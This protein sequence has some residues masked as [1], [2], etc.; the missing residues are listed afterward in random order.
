MSLNHPYSAPIVAK[1]FMDNVYKLHDLLTSIVSDR[2]TMFL[3]KFW[4]EMFSIQGVNLLYLSVYCPQT[5][6]QTEIV[7]K[8]VENYLRCM[9]G[10][11]PNQWARWLLLAKWWY[12]MNFHSSTKLTPYEVLYN[13]SPPIHVPYFPKD[14]TV[15]L[16]NDLLTKREEIIKQIKCNLRTAQHRITQIANNKR[17]FF[18]GDYVHLKLQHYKQQLVVRRASQKLSAKFFDLYLV[19]DMVDK[20]AYK[21]ELPPSSAIHHVFHVS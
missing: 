15:E 9:T 18:I 21:L 12:N 2:D 19:I 8:Y 16:I 1:I 14:S 4:K 10:D 5:N 3:S 11:N 7:N 6:G 17:S 20:V 13:F